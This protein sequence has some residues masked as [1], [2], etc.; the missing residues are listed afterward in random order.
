MENYKKLAVVVLFWNDYKKTIKCLKSIYCQK[1]INFSLVLVDNNSKL[2]QDD[3]IRD[4]IIHR[5]LTITRNTRHN[6]N[7][8][9]GASVRAAI[10]IAE[11]SSELKFEEACKIALFSRVELADSNNEDWASTFAD[12]DKKKEIL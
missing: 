5:S 8:T 7:F 3:D 4:Q 1:K 11:L 9:R 12:L 6:P 10:A 2:F